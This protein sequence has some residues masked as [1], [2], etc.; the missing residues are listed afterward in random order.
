[1]KGVRARIEPP[2]IV[3][4]EVTEPDRVAAVDIDGVSSVSLAAVRRR[5]PAAPALRARIEHAD[6]AEFVFGKPDV[7]A[8][9]ERD[10]AQ[11]RILARPRMRILE[12]L[13]GP[14]IDFDQLVGDEFGHPDMTVACDL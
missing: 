7:A 13:A 2:N 12:R 3:A 5:A 9:V 6:A 14:R 8:G 4:T 11:A 1:G 10:P